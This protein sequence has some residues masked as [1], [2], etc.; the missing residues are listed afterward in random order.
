MP[1]SVNVAALG[2]GSE[3]K[4]PCEAVCRDRKAALFVKAPHGTKL[5]ATAMDLNKTLPDQL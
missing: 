3:G 1:F 2:D 5:N 4:A